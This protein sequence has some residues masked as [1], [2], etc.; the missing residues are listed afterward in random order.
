MQD[1]VVRI[2]ALEPGCEHLAGR[3]RVFAAAHGNEVTRDDVTQA[4]RLHVVPLVF[5][6]R[7]AIDVNRDVEHGHGAGA[8]RINESLD[9]HDAVAAYVDLVGDE[10]AVS[11]QVAFDL[12][13]D[14][15]AEI[16]SGAAFE[17]RLIVR[18]YGESRDVEVC[19][20]VEQRD[21]PLDLDVVVGV[22]D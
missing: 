7:Q 17:D 9:L 19:C 4:E 12:D 6:A 3:V 8:D 14:V 5:Y 16:A 22:A 15:E 2:V 13:L 21:Q 18:R 20:I 10:K 11:V 1:C